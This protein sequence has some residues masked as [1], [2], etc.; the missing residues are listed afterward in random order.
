MLV[1]ALL[2]LKTVVPVHG[3][4]RQ[5][6]DNNGQPFHKAF[7]KIDATDDAVEQDKYIVGYKNQLGL[8]TARSQSRAVRLNLPNVKAIATTMTRSQAEA[9][10]LKSSY[11]SLQ[12][13]AR[14]LS[15]VQYSILYY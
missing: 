3:Q 13:T 10:K 9:L 15:V 7:N 5:P 14:G 6:F 8:E 4:Q 1:V 2:G 12:Y 11:C